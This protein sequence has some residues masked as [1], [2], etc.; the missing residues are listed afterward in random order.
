M[1]LF[2]LFAEPGLRI[3]R[4]SDSDLK[5]ELAK[6][7]DKVMLCSRLSVPDLAEDDGRA[8]YGLFHLSELVAVMCV[9]APEH[10]PKEL[11]QRS[12]GDL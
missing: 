5:S 4:L 7:P 8:V 11:L 9:A 12:E 2:D 10:Q 6:A 3:V 1:N